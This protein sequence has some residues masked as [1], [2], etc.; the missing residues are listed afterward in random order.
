MKFYTAINVERPIR[1]KEETRK[2]AYESMHG[3][4]GDEAIKN[5][6]VTLDHI[7]GFESLSEMEKYNVAIREIATKAPIRIC[8]HE[9]I[10][11]SATLGLSISHTIPA[12]YKGKPL[13]PSISHLTAGFDRVV[14]EG[15]DSYEERIHKRLEDERLT[16]RQREFLRSLLNVIE[17]MRIWHKRYKEKV[18][19]SDVPFKPALNFKEAV[20]SLWFSFAFMRLC[21]DWPGIGR[22]DKILGSYLKQD[23]DKGDITIDEAREVLASFF[24]KGC[25]W[26]QSNTPAGSGDAQHYQNIV[27]AG[28]D[29]NNVEVTNEVTYLVLDIIEELGISDFPIT[30]RINENT[31]EKL[32]RRVAEVMRHG[33]GVVA[34]YNEPLILQGMVNLG[35]SPEEAR[36]F[37]NDGCWE[38]QIPGETYFC[39]VPFDGLQILLSKTLNINGEYKVFDSFDELYNSFLDNLRMDIQA[40]YQ[41]VVL[42]RFNKTER[43]WEYKEMFP[44][45]VTSLFTTGCI[46]RAA[47]YFEGGPNYTVVSPHI[48]GAPDVG[49]SLYAIKKLVFDDKV[50]TFDE[51]MKA[52]KANWEGYEF[53][54]Q[55]ALNKYT[56]YGNDDD[57]G[58]YYTVK[59]LNDFADIVNSVEREVPILFPAGI[60]TFGRQIEWA[61]FREAVP[62]GYRKGDLLSGNASPTPGTDVVGATATIKSYCKIDHV[63]QASGSALDI[64]LY[65]TTLQGENGANAIV[66]LIKGFVQ[67]G[68]FFMQIDVID[69]EA[70]IRAQENPEEYKTLSVRVSG[71]NARFV[72]LNKEW[73]NMIIERTALGV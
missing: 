4:Y 67:L 37:A 7:E 39:Y 17:S 32:L 55:T 56:Y 35:Y 44:C 45:S 23:L 20:Q 22:I 1:L 52:L 70:L 53:I 43:G 54:R 59:V 10:H 46:E 62:F 58:D 26:I 36:K 30:V 12:I 33:G 61:P 21:G 50:I 51:L 71:W 19:I 34:V 24:I 2:F 9:L 15:I 65:P 73:Q 25:E 28:L 48:G 40:I 60:S 72:T 64:K 69:A 42:G 31:E 5:Y 18:D 68:G 29:E 11:G 13:F 16:G 41:H 6:C 63:K 47:S 57:D 49:N 27:L 8:E 66:S 3:K 14:Y 38:V